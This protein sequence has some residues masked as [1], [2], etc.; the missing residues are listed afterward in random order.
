MNR[1]FRIGIAT[2]EQI[3]SN[4]PPPFRH[5][6][7]IYA[8][9]G[10]SVGAVDFPSSFWMDFAGVLLFRWYTA[11]W[12]LTEDKSRYA[13]LPFLHTYEMWLRRTTK[14]W[15]R[16]SLVECNAESRNVTYETLLIPEVVE[17]ALLT[18]MQKLIV[19]ARRAAVWTEDCAALEA[20]LNDR[21]DYLGRLEDG[22]IRPPTF[23][24]SRFAVPIAA[25]PKRPQRVS[26]PLL[27]G[28]RLPPGMEL[29]RPRQRR[30]HTPPFLCPRCTAALHL[31]SENMQHQTCP[32][33]GEHI[34]RVGPP[35][36][37]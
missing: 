27:E 21:G 36:N 35:P 33:C 16:L 14:Q 4:P 32:L 5:L 23:L 13:R 37:Q 25:H 12:K 28:P 11:V 24:T 34:S 30:V 2:T 29:P 22:S 20:L 8:P 26:K 19:G 18:A 1:S 3:L 6:N 17:S 9:F 15:W 7:V 10:V 31:W